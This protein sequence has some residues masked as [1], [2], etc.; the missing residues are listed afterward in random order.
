MSAGLVLLAVLVGCGSEQTGGA[1][2]AGAS[3]GSPTTGSGKQLV[4]GAEKLMAC[5]ATPSRPPVTKSLPD[6]SLPCL[7]EGPDIRLADLRGPLLVNVW[8]QWCPPC[9][10]EAPY[11]ADLHR[12][13]G[14]KLQVLG[15]DYDDP[16]A[17][18]AVTFAVDHQLTYPHLVDTDKQLA[19]PLRIAGPPL[20][21]FV[22]ADGAVAYVH[23]GP[24]TSQQE[25]DQLVK[26]KLG[27][28]L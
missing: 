25:L 6:V 24:F 21:A 20:T 3:T 19:S 10:A 4:V 23:R 28:S 5:P 15:V 1:P 13:A 8:A 26:D 2:A 17:D 14:G 11:L 12:R 16:R 18:Q 7:G 9:R 27:V 22:D